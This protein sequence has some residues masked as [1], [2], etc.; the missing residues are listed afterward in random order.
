MR[1]VVKGSVN[2][3]HFQKSWEVF[4]VSEGCSYIHRD[5]LSYSPCR[6]TVQ[7][8]KKNVSVLTVHIVRREKPG[9][10]CGETPVQSVNLLTAGCI[11]GAL[12]NFLRMIFQ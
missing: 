4:W 6:R 12:C 7:N 3:A 5:G 2:V 8:V 10:Y 1:V 9:F 11:R